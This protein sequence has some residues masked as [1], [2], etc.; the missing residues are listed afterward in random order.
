MT[1][2]TGRRAAAAAAPDDLPSKRPAA[3]LAAVQAETRAEQ[4][5]DENGAILVT[6]QTRLGFHDVR[7]PPYEEWTSVAVH[8][9]NRE[10]TLTWAQHTLAPADAMMWMRLNPTI[11]EARAF[12]EEWGR[13]VGQSLGESLA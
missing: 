9:M 8:A 7:V 6:L 12:F 3:A 10:D 11:K 2:P 13:K 5:V 4:L 1:K